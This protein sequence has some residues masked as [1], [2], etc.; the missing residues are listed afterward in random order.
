MAR[1]PK[2]SDCI[3][4]E[5]K[6]MIIQNMKQGD[7]FPTEKEL[8]RKLGVSRSTIRESIKVLVALGLLTN[9]DGAK[10]VNNN[11]SNYLD[12]PF[13][14][15]LSMDVCSIS[16]LLQLRSLL[17]VGVITLVTGKLS[18]EIFHQLERIVWQLQNPD[19]T[20]E[21]FIATEVRFHETLA[22]ATDNKLLVGLLKTVRDLISDNLTQTCKSITFKDDVIQDRIALLRALRANDREKAEA[23]TRDHI[24]MSQLLYGYKNSA[25]PL[26]EAQLDIPNDD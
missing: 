6:K 5:M 24:K 7:K 18:D 15:L 21:E 8:E 3:I 14:I 22:D 9:R 11:A 13:N 26:T 20:T 16:D 4:E 25:N 1:N 23:C 19:L 10:Y 2:L 12:S 17:E